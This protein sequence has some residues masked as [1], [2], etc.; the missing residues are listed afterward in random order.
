MNN[1]FQGHSFIATCKNA[2]IDLEIFQKKKNISKHI[3]TI[4]TI[5]FNIFK[6]ITF[7]SGADVSLLGVPEPLARN[8]NESTL[9]SH[10][11]ITTNFKTIK[12]SWIYI[13][14]IT[15]HLSNYNF[16]FDLNLPK[17]PSL[18]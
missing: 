11:I 7:I 6:A 17:I 13:K 5:V 1:I 8:N 14:I 15:Y 4:S 2:K 12:Q 10:N 18:P 16:S 9:E 3:N